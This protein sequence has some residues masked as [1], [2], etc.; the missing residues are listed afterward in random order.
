M[1]AAAAML[2]GGYGLQMARGGQEAQGAQSPQQEVNV[3]S[4]RHYNTDKR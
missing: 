4:G 1:L 2:G 3:Y